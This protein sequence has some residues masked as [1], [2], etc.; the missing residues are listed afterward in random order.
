MKVYELVNVIKNS[1]S[2]ININNY[3][4]KRMMGLISDKGTDDMFYPSE[5]LLNAEI[6]DT[7][8]EDETNTLII[9]VIK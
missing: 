4:N 3:Y 1:Y 8:Y 9:Y 6:V 7:M 5:E 2:S